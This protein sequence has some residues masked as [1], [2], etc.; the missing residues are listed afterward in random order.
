[1]PSTIATASTFGHEACQTL[2]PMSPALGRDR[3]RAMSSRLSSPARAA[4]SSVSA[5]MPHHLF[6]QPGLDLQGAL[7]GLAGVD[8]ARPLGGHV[9]VLQHAAGAAAEQHHA[10]AEADGL[11][12][13]VGDEQ[14]AE[15][16]PAP[17]A[18]QQL[19]QQV[20]G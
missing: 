9:E 19:V 1:M 7:H 15:P 8:A 4:A 3:W 17:D 13:L 12:D 5:D 2:A 14:H 10:V 16:L 20:A 18:L 6:V 11:A